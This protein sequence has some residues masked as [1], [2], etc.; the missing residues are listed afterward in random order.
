MAT[1]VVGTTLLALGSNSNDVLI[2]AV[3]QQDFENTLMQ[4]EHLSLVLSP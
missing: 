2:Q 3:P 4:Y 1:S